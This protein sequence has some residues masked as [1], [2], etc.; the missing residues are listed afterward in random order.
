MPEL[1]VDPLILKLLL[2]AGVVAVGALV[3]GAVGFG[4]ALLSAPLLALLEPRLVPGPLIFAGLALTVAMAVR[5]RASIHVGGVGWALAGRVPGTVV[6][7]AVLTVLAARTL[8]IVLGALV[9]AA[10]AMTAFG[11]RIRPGPL[12]LL[13]AG[14]LSGFMGT[15]AS[16][17]GPPVAM[18]YQHESGARIR[19]TL[20]AY[21]TFG[22]TMSL[23]AL[24]VIG[25][26]GTWELLAAIALLP[27]VLAGA[28]LAERA[29]AWLD[30]GRTR[31]AVLAV[32]GISGVLLL[33]RELA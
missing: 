24:A 18:V 7:A 17:G 16:I 22:A 9:L 27:G 20:S 13:L 19:G 26:F 2:A 33:L 31:I 6:G 11:P 21:F 30:A 25:R 12:A 28:V 3:Q 1:L 15:T 10:V 4:L 29:T 32:S 5:E 8:G 23:V 14:V